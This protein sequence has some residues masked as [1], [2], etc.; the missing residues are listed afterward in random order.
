[1]G[2]CDSFAVDFENRLS[3]SRENS[4]VHLRLKTIYTLNFIQISQG[5]SGPI[6]LSILL[7]NINTVL[8]SLFVNRL[9]GGRPMRSR[10]RYRLGTTCIP[11]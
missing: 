9:A 1:M 6:Q 7:C 10:I 2:L 4:D 8:I 11:L 5:A 3:L